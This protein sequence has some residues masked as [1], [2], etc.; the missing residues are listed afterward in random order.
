MGTAEC[1]LDDFLVF[2]GAEKQTDGSAFVS[3]AMVTIERFEI[4]V[5]FAE[6]FRAELAHLE[7]DGDEAIQA[8]MKKEQVESEILRSDLDRVLGTDEAEIA[9]QLGNKAA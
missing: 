8:T 4:E 1:I 2:G 3:L 6:I 7:F 5:E 9:T